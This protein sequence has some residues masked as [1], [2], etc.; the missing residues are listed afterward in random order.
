MQIT[1]Q[2]NP[3]IKAAVKLRDRSGRDEQQRIIIDGSREIQ[4]ALEG[5]VHLLELYVLPER[6][7]D[8]HRQHLVAAAQ[9]HGV[10][11]H[12]VPLSVMEKLSFGQ[13][14]DGLIAIAEPPVR[15]LGDFQP[16]AVGLVA[17]VEGAEKPGN[18]GAVLR[19]ADAA[20]V[21]AVIVADGVTDVFNPNAIRASLGA[22]FTTP[23]YSVT[24]QDA[25][26][27]LRKNQFRIFTARVDAK[28]NYTAV[29]FSGK[30]AVV[31]GSEA[32]GLTEL[33]HADD[34]TAVQVPLLGAVDSLN[35]SATAAILFYEALRQRQP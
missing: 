22:I 34:V 20:G 11:V 24:S 33:W 8:L 19:T 1:S 29:N 30:A 13:R 35:L 12:E 17:V 27:W 3:R 21:R 10:D 6:C 31:L 18:I 9:Q 32:H 26:A 7:D 14:V 5:G 23:V 28:L 25:L 16:P 2:H 15:N 4:R